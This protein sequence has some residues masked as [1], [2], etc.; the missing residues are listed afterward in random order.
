ME[1]QADEGA[2][3][4]W[5][6]FRLLGG[7]ELTELS[8]AYVACRRAAIAR[9]DSFAKVFAQALA[10]WNAQTPASSG[11]VV[12]VEQAL[13]RVVAPIAA[14][15]PVLLLV[16]DGLSSSIFRELFARATSHGW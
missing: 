8:D 9:R 7:D 10:Q 6:R 16:M 15:Q 14:T 11:R 1:W 2:Y 12:L 4:D 13:D 3:V 5:A